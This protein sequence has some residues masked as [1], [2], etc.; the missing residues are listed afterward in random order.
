[1]PVDYVADGIVALLDIDATGT[2]NLVAGE[3]A[4]TVDDLFELT[5][6]HLGRPRPRYVDPGGS[7]GASAGDH[8][9]VYL[10]YFDV[11]GLRRRARARPDRAAAADPRRTSTR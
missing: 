10:P 5:C 6:K 3:D 4:A 9:D 1:M 8:G 11:R 7:A 2:F